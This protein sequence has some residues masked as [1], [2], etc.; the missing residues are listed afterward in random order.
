MTIVVNENKFIEKLKSLGKGGLGKSMKD[1]M[2]WFK[3]KVKE[4]QGKSFPAAKALRKDLHNQGRLASK[5]QLGNMYF[6]RYDPK[7]KDKLPYYDTYPLIFPFKYE[8]QPNPGF[9][10]VNLHYLYLNDRAILMDTLKKYVDGKR[11]NLTEG[12][13]KS[14]MKSQKR[15]VPCVKRYVY[16]QVQG[17]GFINIDYDEWDYAFLLPVQKFES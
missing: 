16:S 8:I 2:N 11:L 12:I 17:K 4:I 10:G 9:W 15:I 1:S 7:Y 14:L 3:N 5:P 6:Y 13:V